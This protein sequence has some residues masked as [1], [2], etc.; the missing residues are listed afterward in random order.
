MGRLFHCGEH[1]RGSESGNLERFTVSLTSISLFLGVCFVFGLVVCVLFVGF[2]CCFVFLVLFPPT[3]LRSSSC[4]PELTT[5]RAVMVRAA[6][7]KKKISYWPS[8]R[9]NTPEDSIMCCHRHRCI[10]LLRQRGMRERFVR[11]FIKVTDKGTTE[12]FEA[13]AATSMLSDGKASILGA[14]SSCVHLEQIPQFRCS[15]AASPT[16]TPLLLFAVG[17]NAIPTTSQLIFDTSY[18]RDLVSRFDV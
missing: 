1:L 13:E 3:M 14:S 17:P 9:D 2:W 15:I 4:P 12:V 5:V 10:F 18:I 7:E 6:M 8:Q 11:S 16:S